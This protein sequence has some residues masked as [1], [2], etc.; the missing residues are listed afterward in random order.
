MQA[1]HQYRPRDN[2]H[3]NI[4]QKGINAI[5]DFYRTLAIDEKNFSQATAFATGMNS[6]FLNVLFDL[7]T[8][9]MNS[10]ELIHAA[11]QFFQMHQV[12]YGWFIIPATAEHDLTQHG[13]TLCE[14]APAMYFDLQNSLP[15]SN[16]EFI[17]IEEANDD[18][19]KWI[20]P[21]KD[22][23]EV[24]EEDD[25]YRQLNAAILQRGVKKLRHFIAY[26]QN[27]L[28]AAGTLFLSDDAVMI[29]NVAT[30]KIYKNRGL[31]TAITLHMMNIAKELGY[32]HCYLDASESAFSLY[33]KIGF[34]VYATTLIY[35][36]N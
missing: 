36:K 5:L 23:F 28:A 10:A 4:V 16:A 11:D 35:T 24:P 21:I 26:F 18:L 8:E 22:G 12:P 9:R 33:K 6:P 30:K 17:T 15:E 29:H 13:F 1:Q 19:K 2:M 27:E 31:G 7:R 20:Q 34:S 32:Q 3:N 14:E 25:A